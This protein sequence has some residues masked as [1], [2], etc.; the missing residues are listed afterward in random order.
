MVLMYDALEHVGS[1]SCFQAD[2]LEPRG[3]LVNVMKLERMP[4][5]HAGNSLVHSSLSYDDPHKLH[6]LCLCYHFPFLSSFTIRD[7][8]GVGVA[9]MLV[10]SGAEA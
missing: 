8:L 2:I 7:S 1:C 5:I 9:A 4:H 6:R 3:G 10:N